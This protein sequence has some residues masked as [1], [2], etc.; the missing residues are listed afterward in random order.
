MYH[1]QYEDGDSEDFDLEEYQFAFEVR[2]A[3]DSGKFRRDD[4]EGED[5]DKIS[6]DGTEDEWNETD[7]RS[8]SDDKTTLRAKKRQP[9]TNATIE[10][11]SPAK[12][13]RAKTTDNGPTRKRVRKAKKLM[14]TKTYSKE[15]VLVEFGED[16]E[17]GQE[18]RKMD[19]DERTAA[20]DVLNR[21]ASKGIKTVVKDKILTTKYSTLC[22]DKLKAHLLAERVPVETMFRAAETLP[23]ARSASAALVH[24]G[25]WVHVDAD[26]SVGFNS[27]GGIAVVIGVNDNFSDVK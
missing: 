24:V 4:I 14:D 16:S 12:R 9:I 25:D 7:S 18:Y 2:K 22:N 1:V 10:A 5:N 27:E 26:R 20:L 3:L 19:A 15:S 13:K 23:F 11:N 17:F 21:G 6:N 8:D